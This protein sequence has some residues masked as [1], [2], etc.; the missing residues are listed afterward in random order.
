VNTP[1][2]GLYSFS[3]TDV[4]PGSYRLFAGTDSDNDDL[5]CDAGEACGAYRTLDAPEVLIVEGDRSDLDFLSGFR[6]N[7]GASSS[8]LTAEGDSN[9]T[10]GYTINKDMLNDRPDRLDRLK[11]RAKLSP[12]LHL[13]VPSVPSVPSIE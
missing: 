7:F 1:R 4:P 13:S 9:R 3:F 12:E 6:Q 5:L 8:A 2:D 10:R 11:E